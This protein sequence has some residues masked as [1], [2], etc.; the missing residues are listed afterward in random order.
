MVA[1]RTVKITKK[2]GPDGTISESMQT[3]TS[4]QESSSKVT[5]VTMNDDSI[6]GLCSY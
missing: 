5:R 6:L 1:E 4:S 2:E 3:D